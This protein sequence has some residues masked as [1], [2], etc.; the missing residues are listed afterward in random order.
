MLFN[1]EHHEAVRKQR[2]EEGVCIHCGFDGRGDCP[3]NRWPEDCKERKDG[4]KGPNTGAML[5]R[6]GVFG[7]GAGS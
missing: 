1:E 7:R 3:F 2:A 4:F 5:G 6:L